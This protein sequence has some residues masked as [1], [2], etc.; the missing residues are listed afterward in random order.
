MKDI[1]PSLGRIPR[2]EK[3]ELVLR[4][5]EFT[6]MFYLKTLLKNSIIV[7]QIITE[8]NQQSPSN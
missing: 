7:Q 2:T 5:I 6:W 3:L 4:G 8:M 1:R